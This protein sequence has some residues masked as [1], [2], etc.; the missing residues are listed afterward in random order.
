MDNWHSVKVSA[1]MEVAI[2]ERCERVGCEYGDAAIYVMSLGV[3]AIGR[4]IPLPLR[5][6]FLRGCERW[7]LGVPSVAG[8]SEGRVECWRYHDRNRTIMGAAEYSAL[9]ALI[10]IMYDEPSADGDTAE[11]IGH[12]AD[13]AAQ[14]PEMIAAMGLK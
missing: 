14:F 3:M 7:Y 9:R 11:G 12:F 2:D 4:H 1:S 8:L 5:R 13:I 10:F 6:Q